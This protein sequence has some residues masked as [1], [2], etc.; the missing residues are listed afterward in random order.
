MRGNSHDLL[1]FRAGIGDQDDS[2]NEEIMIGGS[3]QDLNHLFGL[4][5]GR[6]HHQRSPSLIVQS[7]FINRPLPEGPGQIGEQQIDAH[8]EEHEPS[9]EHLKLVDREQIQEVQRHQKEHILDRGPYLLQCIPAQDIFIGLHE[10]IHQKLDDIKNDDL[11][12]V[13]DHTVGIARVD[14]QDKAE[15]KADLQ[16]DQIQYDE[17]Q[18]LEHTVLCL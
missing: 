8:H 15:D 12:S 9:G 10:E 18:M 16:T 5:A 17:I 11:I 6:D 7:L 4:I 14:Q 1:L 3:P 13:K 2:G